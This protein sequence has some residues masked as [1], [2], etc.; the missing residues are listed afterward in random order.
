M[1]QFCK[2]IDVG[3]HFLWAMLTWFRDT[4]AV[5]SG[6]IRQSRLALMKIRAAEQRPPAEACFTPFPA[7]RPSFLGVVQ[8]AQY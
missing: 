4:R 2:I 5:F 1:T 3:R 8:N 7:N 6:G